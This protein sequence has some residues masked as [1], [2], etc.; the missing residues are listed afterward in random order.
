MTNHYQVLIE[1]P[2]GNLSK[3]MR[4]LNGVFTQG[5]N[6]R[7]RR[8]GHLFQGRFK[9]ILVDKDAYLLELTRHVVLNPARARMVLEPGDWP[10]SSY[11]AMVGRADS[12]S[13]L[14][15]DALLAQ[16]SDRVAEA[17][18]RY[19]RF[20]AE[21]LGAASS[22][23]HLKGQ[24][25]LGDEEFVKRMQANIE[26]VRTDVNIPKRQ[27]RPRH[28][29]SNSLPVNTPTAIKPSWPAIALGIIPT[30]RSATFSG[31]ISRRWGRSCVRARNDA[32][33]FCGMI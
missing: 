13:W 30:R 10:W 14:E 5:S 2:D 6:R 9:G 21:G 15:T 31:C 12:P 19:A 25:Y 4:Q 17:R 7:H 16:F 24:I 22:W 32:F 8:C 18:K 11:R 33:G 26:N 29:P 27:R 20:V 23:E 28:L 1:T 3:G